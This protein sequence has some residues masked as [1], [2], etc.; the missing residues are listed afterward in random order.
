MPRVGR[1]KPVSEQR[2]S[3]LVSMGVLTLTFPPEPVSEV[4]VAAGRKG[5]QRSLP[6][7]TMAYF[8]IGMALH[9]AGTYENVLGLLKDGLGWAAGAEPVVLPSKPTIFQARDLLGFEPVKALFERVAARLAAPDTLGAFL[10][11]RRMVAI[12]GTSLYVAD[13]AVNDEHFGD[14]SELSGV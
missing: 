12:E 10:A 4:I 8:A 13:T 7:Q 1:V 3:D 9:S 6:V 11:G 5:W 14:S 2:I